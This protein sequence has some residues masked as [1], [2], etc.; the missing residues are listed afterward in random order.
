MTTDEKT[1]RNL[2]TDGENETLEF[3]LRLHYERHENQ[4]NRSPQKAV[5]KALSGFLNGK[6]G[7]LLI[8]VNDSG[9]RDWRCRNQSLFRSRLQHRFATPEP[10]KARPGPGCCKT[11]PLCKSSSLFVVVFFRF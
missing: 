8:G 1:I 2:M 11:A 10:L 9:G 7:T 5:I 3:K 4:V 6:G